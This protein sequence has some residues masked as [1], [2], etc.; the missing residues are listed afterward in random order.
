ML[1]NEINDILE[2][3]DITTLIT[4]CRFFEKPYE[5]DSIKKERELKL[6]TK[7]RINEIK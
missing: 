6:S 1:D 7:K 3:S 5:Y 4:K 2:K